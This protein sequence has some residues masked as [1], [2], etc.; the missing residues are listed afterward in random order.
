MRKIENIALFDMDGTLCDYDKGLFNSLEKLRFPEEPV[1]LPPITDDCPSYIKAR[2]ELI[3]SS[4]IWW[5]NLPR[6]QL[7]FDILNVAKELGYREMILTQGPRRNPYSWSG[8]KIWIDKNLG[9]DVD[10]TITRDKGLVY[11]KILVDDFPAYV[12]KW[13]QWRP[14]GLVIMPAGKQNENFK[15]SQVIRY[16]GS[17]LEEVTAAMEK[18][19]LR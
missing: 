18:V 12:E 16:D 1:L 5:A 3:K 17:N 9:P 15:H 11:G 4:E 10:I 19:K 2:A 8:K 7:G 6:F 13:L 14:R